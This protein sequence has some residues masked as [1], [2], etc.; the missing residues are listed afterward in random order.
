[1]TDESRSLP[2]VA[3]VLSVGGLVLLGGLLV[4]SLPRRET[5]SAQ[6]YLELV[7]ALLPL[8]GILFVARLRLDDQ[9]GWPLFLGLVLLGAHYVADVADEVVFVPTLVDVVLEDV[10]ILVGTLVVLVAVYRWDRARTRRERLLEERENRVSAVN[11]Q[12]EVLTRLMRHDISNDIAVARGW[13]TVLDDHVDDEGR[14]ALERVTRACENVAELTDTAYDLVTVLSG[15]ADDEEN[16]LQTEAVDVLG[17]LDEEVRKLQD[18]YDGVEVSVEYDTDL[19]GTTVVA[20][21]LLRSVFGNLLSN[22]VAHNDSDPP[23]VSVSAEREGFRFRVRV[24]DNGPGLPD[25]QKRTVF[26]KD[27][28]GLDSG[29]TGIGLFLVRELVT[30]FGGSVHAVDNEPRGAVFVVDLPVA[31]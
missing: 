23:R 16:G 10:T 9:V 27:V 8:F 30:R 7:V 24:A 1:M 20:N 13:A 5:V 31:I 15:D 4:W 19:A 25:D 22:A 3:A 11:D 14:A 6:I 2:R 29:G 28:R 17:V 21:E 26:E 18:R 12:L